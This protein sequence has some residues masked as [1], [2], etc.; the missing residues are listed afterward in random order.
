MAERIL[1]AGKR[2][3]VFASGDGYNVEF[4]ARFTGVELSGID[5]NGL[6][7]DNG[8]RLWIAGCNGGETFEAK[9]VRG[10]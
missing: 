5:F 10:R 2:Y 9:E 3:H 7:F 8:V 1:L 4:T 6:V